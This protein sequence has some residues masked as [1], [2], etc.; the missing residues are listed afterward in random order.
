MKTLTKTITLDSQFAHLYR[1][2]VRNLVAIIAATI[3]CAAAALIY[4]DHRL[5]N[6]LSERLIENSSQSTDNK[7]HRLFESADRGLQIAHQ[8]LA[9]Y[10]ISNP[11]DRNQI[12][13]TLE[14]YLIELDFL[15]SINLA[16]LP[17]NEYVLIKQNNE[18]LTRHVLA[19]TPTQAHWRRRVDGNVI[20]EWTRQIDVSPKDRPWYQGA[21]TRKPGEQFWTEPYSFLTTKEP[22][23]SLS[24]HSPR[25]EAEGE[26]IAA[27]NITL[28]DISHFTTKLRP[29][30]HGMTVVFDNEGKTI[31]LPPDPRFDDNKTL[32]S[33]VLSPLTELGVPV[34]NVAVSTWEELGKTEAIFSFDA[35]DH[36]TWWAGFSLMSLD[37]DRSLWTA[38]LIP[39]RD[40]LGT[41]A[42]IRNYVLAGISAIG[43]LIAAALFGTSMRSIRHQ[44]KTVVDQVERKLGQY[45]LKQKIGEGGNGTVYRAQH[46]LLRRP[47]AIK[48]MNPAFASSEAAR[49]RFEHEVQITSNLS[50]PN[51]IAIY[52]YGQTPEGTLYYAM[53]LLNGS[54][55]EN[56]IRLGGPLLPGRVIHIL[57]Q[58]AGSLAEAHDK[59][60]IHRDIKPSNVILCERG[61]VYDVVK[62]LDF[63]LVKEI[64]QTDGNLTQANVL[65]GTPLY[66]APE[67]ISQP[68]QASPLSDIYALGAVGYFL[69]TARNVFEGGSAVEI[70]AKHLNDAPVPP[71]QRSGIVVPTDLEG[72]ILGCLEKDPTRRPP[73]AGEL[74]SRLLTCNDAGSWTDQD[75][76]GWWQHHSTSSLTGGST[77]HQ[78]TPLSNTELLVDLDNR[79]ASSAANGTNS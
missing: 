17:G 66:M 62:V 24:T 15:D 21:L 39:E 29:S 10:D 67:I 52:D 4:F 44:M 58:I 16:D 30:S 65:I 63:G 54:T 37:E 7:L 35:Q 6:S 79:L 40:F 47:T 70:C 9:P 1:P 56:L 42:R 68:G 69:L 72:I 43:M 19:D 50:H 13:S 45:K 12:F 3:V 60:L 51:T 46:A 31:G 48:L 36:S 78:P 20:E 61:G 55:L 23:I 22:G 8:Q 64:S 74:R 57:E 14:P 59:N 53:E 73:D 2:L 34:L 71:S 11:D 49:E 38:T 5:V 75:A 26:L 25:P 18:I 32:V 76:R 41:I 28:T 33:E 27:F 77:P